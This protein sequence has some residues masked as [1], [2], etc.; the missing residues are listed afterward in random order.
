MDLAEDLG[1]PFPRGRPHPSPV[2]VELSCE[3]MHRGT[4]RCI[5]NANNSQRQ[6]RNQTMK[7]KKKKQQK[8]KK[9]Y[10]A[11]KRK[12]KGEK[13][14]TRWEE[15][16]GGKK[17][18]K[19][20]LSRG[21]GPSR[22]L[23]CP[24]SGGYCSAR[25]SGARGGSGARGAGELGCPPPGSDRQTADRPTL[26]VGAPPRGFSLFLRQQRPR[27]GQGR[28]SGRLFPLRGWKAPVWGHPTPCPPEAPVPADRA[29]APAPPTPRPRCQ[30]RRESCS[31]LERWRRLLLTP[32]LSFSLPRWARPNG[33]GGPAHRARRR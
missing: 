25:C 10:G 14:K 32:L 29:G 17:Q 27:P 13:K 5:L 31:K 16:R 21:A 11:G 7:K 9:K 8:K 24:G 18:L 15:K 23:C 19:I 6:R 22:R 30:P 12:E 2:S 28:G 26:G 1:T 33:T 3:A 20:P 4:C